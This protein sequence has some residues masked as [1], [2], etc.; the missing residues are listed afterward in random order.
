MNAFGQECE[1]S[2]KL[3]NHKVSLNSRRAF[4]IVLNILN[5]VLQMEKRGLKLPTMDYV[6][7]KSKKLEEM[8][9]MSLKEEDVEKVSASEVFWEAFLTLLLVIDNVC[10]VCFCIDYSGEEKV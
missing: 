2:N 4:R 6:R 9:N 10:L 1:L 3:F 7:Q 5:I 8:K